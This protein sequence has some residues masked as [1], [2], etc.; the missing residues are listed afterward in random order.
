MI[1]LLAVARGG[2]EKYRRLRKYR[3]GLITRDLE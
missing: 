2:L 3:K 1:Y